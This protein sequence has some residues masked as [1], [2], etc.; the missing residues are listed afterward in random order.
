MINDFWR[1]RLGEGG[2]SEVLRVTKTSRS[3][4]LRKRN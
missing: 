2:Y 4:I 3:D 1:R